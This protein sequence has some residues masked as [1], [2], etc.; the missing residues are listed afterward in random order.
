[1][2]RRAGAAVE[3]LM[4]ATCK[5]SIVQMSISCIVGPGIVNSWGNH[6]TVS[7]VLVMVDHAR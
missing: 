4:R 5:S 3:N 7:A 2:V 6:A 1:M